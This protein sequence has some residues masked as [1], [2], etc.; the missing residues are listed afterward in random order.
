MSGEVDRKIGRAHS[1]LLK[2]LFKGEGTDVEMID[3]QQ[4]NENLETTQEQ[5]VEDAHVTISTCYKRGLSSSCY[6]MR[7]PNTK[8]PHSFLDLFLSSN[9]S[10]IYIPL[11][12]P[13]LVSTPTPPPTTKATNPLSTLL[14][15]ALVFRFND[16]ITA[17]EKEVAELKKDPLHTQVT[18]LVD[19]HQDTR[20]IKESH[21]EVTLAKVSSQ[22][23]STYEAASTLTEFELNKILLDKDRE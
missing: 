7:L 16:R 1:R 18:T 20:L 21:D 6:Y 4:R 9:H 23:Q 17:L 19:E 15:F 14:D 3:A 5:V 22:P 2:R 12:P 10:S 13:P 11:P 8:L